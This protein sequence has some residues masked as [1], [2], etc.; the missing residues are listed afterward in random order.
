MMDKTGFK[1]GYLLFSDQNTLEFSSCSCIVKAITDVRLLIAVFCF[2]K[3]VYLIRKFI[4][5]VL[6]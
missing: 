5:R 4:L 3:S 1:L 2:V 6:K